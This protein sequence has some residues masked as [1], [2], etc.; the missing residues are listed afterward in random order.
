MLLGLKVD[1]EQAPWC[2]RIRRTFQGRDSAPTG[3]H[4]RI[5]CTEDKSKS[6]LQDATLTIE[7][8][9]SLLYDKRIQ[10]SWISCNILRGENLVPQ[11][12]FSPERAWLTRKWAASTFPCLVFP[13]HVSTLLT[14]GLS[15]LSV[16]Q[17]SNVLIGSA[18]RKLTLQKKLGWHSPASSSL[19]RWFV[20]SLIADV[21][22]L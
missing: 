1:W 19:L 17:P 13:P 4:E 6:S 20:W 14:P 12:N 15:D 21:L 10:T 2:V 3:A 7:A 11:Q 5:C 18:V 22:F 16:S 8:I 9:L